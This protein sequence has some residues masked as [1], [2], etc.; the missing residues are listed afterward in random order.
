MRYLLAS[1]AFF[2]V[3]GNAFASGGIW[4]ETGAAPAEINVHGGV[5]RGMGGQLFSFEGKVSIADQSVPEDLRKLD[6][7][8]EHVTQYWFDGDSVN[9]VLY[10]ERDAGKLHGSLEISIET[11]ALKGD[12]NEGSYAGSYKVMVAYATEDSPEGKQVDLTGAINCFAD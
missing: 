8:R 1:C 4:C 2:L 10:N 9:L 6:F 11:K 3:S 7:A 12:D 5:S